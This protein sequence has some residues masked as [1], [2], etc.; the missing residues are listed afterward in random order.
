M[1]NVF[2]GKEKSDTSQFI[3]LVNND[4]FRKIKWQGIL[5]THVIYPS[6][7]CISRIKK[8]SQ[9]TSKKIRS[10]TTKITTCAKIVPLKYLRLS[11]KK[12][13]QYFHKSKAN[14]KHKNKSFIYGL[15]ILS[16]FTKIKWNSNGSTTLNRFCVLRIV[17]MREEILLDIRHIIIFIPNIL[18][19][20]I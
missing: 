4:S 10:Q 12:S 16:W 19:S 13:K 6:L 7:N 5:K 20:K 1:N 14:F 11:N 3:T 9:L 15:S 17:L 18:L 2:L 8:L